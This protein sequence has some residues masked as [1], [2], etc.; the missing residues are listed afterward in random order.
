MVDARTATILLGTN[1]SGHIMKRTH[2]NARISPVAG[3]DMLSRNEVSRL[4]DASQGGSHP[5]LRRCALAVLT[6]GMAMDD[7]RAMLDRYSD[8]DIQDVQQDRGIKLELINAPAQAF[9]D[10]KIIRGVSE[11]LF[12]VLR[13]VVYITSQ[14]EAGRFDLNDSHGVTHA[15]FEILRHARVLRPNIEPNLVVCW[16]GHSIPR[17]EYQYTKL[18]GY[19]LCLRGLDIFS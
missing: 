17:H 16:G 7:A 11:L 12:S 18:V 15:V 19:E 8:F 10:G 2:V 1:D 14:I 5:L 4:R 6:Q 13:D 3:M 9:V